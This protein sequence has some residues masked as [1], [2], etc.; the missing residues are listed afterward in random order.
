MLT[1]ALILICII[2]YFMFISKKGST[3]AM[4]EDHMRDLKILLA[5]AEHSDLDKLAQLVGA[6]EPSPSEISVAI[7]KMGGNIPKAGGYSAI[8]RAVAEKMGIPLEE[9]VDLQTLETRISAQ[10][11]EDLWKK[12]SPK[13]KKD[14]QQAMLDEG[15]GDPELFRDPATS[16]A[17]I[18]LLMST[19]GILL[20]VLNLFTLFLIPGLG[21]AATLLKYAG[22]LGGGY[23]G[24]KKACEPDYKLLVPAIAYICALR[25][26]Y[27]PKNSGENRAEVVMEARPL[28]TKPPE[29][30]QKPPSQSGTPEGVRHDESLV[31]AA[32]SGQLQ[33]VKQLV[34]QG[35]PI[36]AM[37]RYGVTALHAAAGAN[38]VQVVEYL[39]DQGA[40]VD[41]RSSNGWTPLIEASSNRYTEIVRLL[42]ERSASVDCRDKYGETA[43]SRATQ[44]GYEEIRRLL[45]EHGAQDDPKKNTDCG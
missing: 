39:L 22:I 20:G 29:A 21:L 16:A 33:L 25:S 4:K 41:A 15:V 26:K 11:L 24:L 38:Q 19:P 17:A 2:L 44:K 8:V 30:S 31:N 13:Q 40:N 3:P 36:N 12:L 18:G 1:A 34:S 32:E 28:A 9:S 45:L 35:A 7:L 10:Y 23:L 6:A 43:L 14:I 27:S 42:L 37:N 5:K